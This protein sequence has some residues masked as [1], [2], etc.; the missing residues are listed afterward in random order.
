MP[1]KFAD[2]T[3]EQLASV[4][5]DPGS[6]DDNWAKN[7]MTKRSIVAQIEATEAQ[8]NAAFWMKMSVIVMALATVLNALVSILT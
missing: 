7:E 1:N 5:G 8:K 3:L 6:R 2:M 4:G